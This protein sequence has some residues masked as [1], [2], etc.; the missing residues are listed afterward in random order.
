[1]RDA[2][3]AK[4]ISTA[5][6]IPGG[7][8]TSTRDLALRGAAWTVMGFGGAQVLRFTFNLILTHLLFPELFGLMALVFYSSRHGYDEA[9]N[10][11]RRERGH[12]DRGK[13][14]LP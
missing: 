14:S 6:A 8:T 1:M 12:D 13:A 3:S 11:D 4:L 5:T 7:P 2:S 9:S 10:R